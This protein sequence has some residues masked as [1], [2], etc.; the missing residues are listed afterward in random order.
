MCSVRRLLEKLVGPVEELPLNREFTECCGFGGLMQN[1]NPDLAKA[2]VR[3]RAEASEK[4]FVTYCA[5]C[6]DNLAAVGKRVV[7]LL[8]LIFPEERGKDPAERPRPG[9]SRR[10]ENRSRLKETLL[11][12]L[13]SEAPPVMEEQQKIELTVSD[14]VQQVLECRRI[15]LEDLQ[16]VIHHAETTGQKLIQESTGHYKASHTPYKAT[17]WVEYSPHKDGFIVHNAYSHRME[18]VGG[19]PS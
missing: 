13:W 5:V 10:Q 11:K 1:A 16:K 12:E 18:L 3:R 19:G 7:H 4:D 15:L 17:F 2:V 9:W 6:R 8:D 14:E